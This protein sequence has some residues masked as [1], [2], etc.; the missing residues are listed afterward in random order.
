MPR[1]IAIIMDGNSRWAKQNGVSRAEGHRAG[2]R[3][4]R[5]VVEIITGL[6]VEFLTLYAFSSENWGRPRSE[7]NGLLRI[8]SELIDTELADLHKK[9]VRL[10]HLGRISGLP[11]KLQKKVNDAVEVTKNNNRL[12]LNIAFDYGGRAEITD[13][14]RRMVQENIQPDEISEAVVSEHLYLPS[15][16]DPELI[17]RTGSGG[18][19]RLS[20]FLLW[21]SAY[22]ELYFTDTFWPDFNQTDMEKALKDY[23]SRKRLFGKR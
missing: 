10:Y 19:T 17:I 15:V 20:N 9:G 14:V 12:T 2:A 8:F 3:N 7:V 18:R 11:A 21:Q 1:H 6:D 16:P 4:I 22:S 23:A 13:A 5:N